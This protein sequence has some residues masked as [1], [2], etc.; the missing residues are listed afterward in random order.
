[1]GP[2][3]S[4]SADCTTLVDC[5]VQEAESAPGQAISTADGLAGTVEQD[6]YGAVGEAEGIAGGAV[7]TAVQELGQV[8]QTLQPYVNAAEQEAGTVVSQ[9]ESL[10]AEAQYLA[11]QRRTTVCALQGRYFAGANATGSL[12]CFVYENSNPTDALNEDG[13][14]GGFSLAASAD[15]EYLTTGTFTVG[16][17]SFPVWF[18]GWPTQASGQGTF[19]YSGHWTDAD[20]TNHLLTAAIQDTPASIIDPQGGSDT[21]LNGLVVLTP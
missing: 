17:R 7:N 19:T 18:G 15:G 3:A 10:A 21:F 12:D 5:A 20:G 13:Q 4:A 11:T 2:V 8:G 6:A 9:A 16:S 14:T 1:M